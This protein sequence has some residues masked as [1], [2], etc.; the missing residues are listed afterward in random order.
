MA[1][2]LSGLA[3]EETLSEGSGVLREQD[4]DGETNPGEIS[5][6]VRKFTSIIESLKDHL[7]Q[8]ENP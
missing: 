5:V 8:P 3:S 7:Q 2:N 1:K 4:S 6:D